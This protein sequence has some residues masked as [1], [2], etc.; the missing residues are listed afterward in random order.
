REDAPRDAAAA[1][2]HLARIAEERDEGQGADVRRRDHRPGDRAGP[3]RL[4]RRGHG[5]QGFR[6]LLEGHALR[7]PAGDVPV[8]HAPRGSHAREH[9][10][11]R[12]RGHA[13]AQGA[14]LIKTGSVPVFEEDETWSSATSRS[15]T[16]TTRPT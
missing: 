7:Q 11:L 12:A 13:G 5:A 8:R 6:E 15:A 1:W 10:A 16:T 4:R 9:G 14:A 2:L 3:L